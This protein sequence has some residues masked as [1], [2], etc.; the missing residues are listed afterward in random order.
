MPKARPPVT[1]CSEGVRSSAECEAGESGRRAS[2][3]GRHIDRN[4]DDRSAVTTI[5]QDAYFSQPQVTANSKRLDGR[6]ERARI[7]PL[8]YPGV[9]STQK[10]SR[11]PVLNGNVHARSMPDRRA[12]P[13]QDN[14][15]KCPPQN[16]GGRLTY[17]LRTG[18]VSPGRCR[19]LAR[20]ER[21]SIHEHA[22]AFLLIAREMARR[23]AGMD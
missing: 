19:D 3:S 10:F 17:F 15:G 7:S 12:A 23:A 6:R 2:C 8:L 13:I 20:F 11:G 16:C 18:R 5:D 1:R 21:V 4:R 9:H 22:H 14:F